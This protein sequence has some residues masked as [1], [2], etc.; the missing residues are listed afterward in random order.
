MRALIQRVQRCEVRITDTVH[1]SIGKGMLI[2]LGIKRDDSEAD[3]A[4][5]AD[6]CASLRIF[7]DSNGKMNLSLRDTEGS[8]M[9]V[10]QFTLY[11]DTRKGNRPSYT[12]AAPAETAEK[13]YNIFVEQLKQI[14]G[15]DKVASGIFKAMMHVELVNDG[16][17]TVMVDSK[18]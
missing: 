3:A 8:A 4:Y 9:V 12:D 14:L 10:S 5:L 17:V 18:V 16:P 2:L 15:H 6:R 13:L 7:D 11:G 1:S